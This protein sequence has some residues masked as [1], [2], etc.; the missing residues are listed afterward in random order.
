MKILIMHF[1]FKGHKTRTNFLIEL[2]QTV[3][4]FGK[5]LEVFRVCSKNMFE[6]P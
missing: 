5:I 4:S 6:K 1:F 3:C 2:G